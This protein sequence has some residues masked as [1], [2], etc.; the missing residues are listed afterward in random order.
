M[1]WPRGDCFARHNLF[2]AFNLDGLVTYILSSNLFK[3]SLLWMVSAPFAAFAVIL[4]GCYSSASSQIVKS[5]NS[6]Y[7]WFGHLINASTC[8]FIKRWCDFI[9]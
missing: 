9:D 6:E 8:R 2:Y 4:V 7:M 5:P 3:A 1:C